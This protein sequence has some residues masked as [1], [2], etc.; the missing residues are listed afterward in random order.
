MPISNAAAAGRWSSLC[1][2]LSISASHLRI[3]VLYLR[4]VSA[5][6]AASSSAAPC[7]NACLAVSYSDKANA[8]N[9]GASHTYHESRWN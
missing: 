9:L 4:V 8:A 7:W 6:P 1:D 5:L 2:L 3:H